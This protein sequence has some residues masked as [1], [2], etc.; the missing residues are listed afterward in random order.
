MWKR[1]SAAMLC[2]RCCVAL[3]RSLTGGTCS[4]F[5]QERSTVVFSGSEDE[6]LGG[7]VLPWAHLLQTRRPQNAHQ[8][9]EPSTRGR[10]TP[11]ASTGPDQRLSH[12]HSRGTRRRWPEHNARC[13]GGVAVPRG[14]LTTFA[15]TN[16][17]GSSA[18]AQPAIATQE[19]TGPGTQERAH[20]GQELAEG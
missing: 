4:S 5:R 11:A 18:P 1:R 15:S 12:Q 8:L 9:L 7:A 3:S 16:L 10:L 20:C 6:T 2:D 19:G 14:N 13:S 17:A